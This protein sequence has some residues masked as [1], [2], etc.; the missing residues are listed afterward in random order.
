M[1]SESE[2]AG[3]EQ[4]ESIEDVFDH[5][6][7]LIG[8]ENDP[9]SVFNKLKDTPGWKLESMR[10]G[11]HSGEGY[12]LRE[13][14]ENG[15]ETGRMIQWHPGGGHHGLQPYYKVSSPKGGT[16]RIGPQFNE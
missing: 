15:R 10:Q 9:D 14:H 8:L 11:D 5:P 2:S 13:Y 1:A 4:I 7:L 6:A 16:V 12:I 3:Q